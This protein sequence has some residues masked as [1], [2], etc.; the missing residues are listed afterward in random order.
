MTKAEVDYI[1]KNIPGAAIIKI[2][3]AGLHGG[4]HYSIHDLIGHSVGG[5]VFVVTNMT[6]FT[7][8]MSLELERDFRNTNPEP[9]SR[10]RASFTSFMHENKLH[11]SEC[12]KS[13]NP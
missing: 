4:R 8:F 3:S 11:W 9:E 10:V 2:E 1:F 5:M 6:Q 13:K 7:E 12:C